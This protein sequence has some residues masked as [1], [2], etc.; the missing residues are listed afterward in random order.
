[1]GTLDLHGQHLEEAALT[2]G[3]SIV[4]VASP[5]YLEV[6]SAANFE[7]IPGLRVAALDR[8]SP[9][10][11]SLFAGASVLVIEVDPNDRAS[12]LR[13][14]DIR[15]KQPHLPVVA[16]INGASVSL[17]RMLVRQGISDV[18]ALPLDIDDLL[19]V[20]LNAVARRDAAAPADQVLAPMIAVAR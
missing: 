9:V 5:A 3:S 1:M 18:V 20:S 15:E 8:G 4:V 2:S 16:A 14:G 13:I 11:A 17:V 6:F 7:A 19:Q 10:P 12:M